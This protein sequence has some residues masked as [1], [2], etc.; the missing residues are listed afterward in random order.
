MQSMQIPKFAFVVAFIAAILYFP[1]LSAEFVFDDTMQIRVDTYI[2]TPANL[3]EVLSL[4]VMSKDIIDNNRPVILLSLMIDS[5]IWGK[6][7]FGYHL[8]NLLLHSLCSALVFIGTYN[9]LKRMFHENGKNINFIWASFLASLLFAIHPIN[10]EAVCTVTFREDLLAAFFTL[11]SLILV[12]YFPANRK[13]IN[14]LLGSC[15][16]VFIFAAVGAKENGVVAPLYLFLYWYFVR[17][18]ESKREWRLLLAAGFAA[19]MIFLIL[20]FTIVPSQTTIFV[21]KAT[22]PGG[23][24]SNMLFLQPRIWIY[25]LLELFRPG[26]ICADITGYSIRNITFSAAVL[27]LVLIV[28]ISILIGR[29]NKGFAI[30]IVFFVLAMLPTSNLIPIFRPVADRYLYLPMF[31]LSLALASMICKI[32][33][34]QRLFKLIS[35]IVIAAICL[36]LCYFTLQREM[37]W[38]NSFSPWQDTA[39]KNP[40][41]FLGNDNLGFV[42]YDRGEYEKAIPYFQKASELDHTSAD[43]LAALAITYDALGR[44]SLANDFAQKAVALNK[45]YGNYDNLLKLLIWTP[46]QAKKLQK[47]TDRLYVKKTENEKNTEK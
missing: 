12:Q 7:A 41:S 47:I 45:Y 31:G 26:L 4:K 19:T 1:I 14:I 46:E 18:H 42:L 13:G 6:R 27:S 8:T 43:P 33:I 3:P 5:M 35:I 36:V 44:K 28:F 24:F 38:N 15:I 16:V 30:G 17:Q 20:R 22:Y 25:Q 11:L 40:Y 9:L 34:P 32:K 37:V 2:H 29:K 10:S 21:Q 39:D 23:S